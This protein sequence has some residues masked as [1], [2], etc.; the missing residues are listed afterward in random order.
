MKCFLTRVIL[1]REKAIEV[2]IGLVYFVF[3]LMVKEIYIYVISAAMCFF[4]NLHPFFHLLTH[5]FLQGNL[6]PK[7]IISIKCLIDVLFFKVLF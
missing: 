1:P 2:L 7:L 3:L 4:S 5:S 6:A